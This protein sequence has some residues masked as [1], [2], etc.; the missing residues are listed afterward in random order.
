MDR[1]VEGAVRSPIGPLGRFLCLG[2]M[3]PGPHGAPPWRAALM[4]VVPAAS[5]AGAQRRGP[6]PSFELRPAEYPPPTV[7]SMRP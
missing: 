1:A 5:A 4:P 6:V 2:A 3:A 7:G